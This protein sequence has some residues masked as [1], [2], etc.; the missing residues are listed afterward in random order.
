MK[1]LHRSSAALAVAT[2]LIVALCSATAA[3]RRARELLIQPFLGDEYSR[4]LMGGIS[5]IASDSEIDLYMALRDDDHAKAFI[6]KFWSDRDAA[7]RDLYERRAAYADDEYTER[8]VSGR[9][10]DRGAVYIVYGAPASVE[11]EEFRDISE[12]DV[13]LWRYPKKAERGL[14]GKKPG[15]IY[16][17][18]RQGR[19]TSFY[20]PPSQEELRRRA[21]LR[22]PRF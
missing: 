17:F 18:A 13:E 1:T 21:R 11:Y 5:F 14:D 7:V 3:E 22:P 15:R 8:H 2:L 4:W 6:V 19:L 10:T 16:R 20:K 12:P 9:L